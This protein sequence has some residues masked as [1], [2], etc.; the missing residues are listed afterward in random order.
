M[1]LRGALVRIFVGLL[2]GLGTSMAAEDASVDRLLKKLPPPE[3]LVK[4]SA[5]QDPALK[6][7]LLTYAITSVMLRDLSQARWYSRKLSEKFPSSEIA[8]LLYGN[9]AYRLRYYGEAEGAFR[10][11]LRLAPT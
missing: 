11:A 8:T 3:K 9:I 10:K 6:D 2:L 4:Q 7:P 1:N 5:P